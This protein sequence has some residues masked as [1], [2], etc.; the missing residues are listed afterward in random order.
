MD[1]PE[2]PSIEGGPHD[3]TPG[4]GDPEDA[5]GRYWTAAMFALIAVIVV[6]VLVVS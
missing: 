5:R 3:N 2:E 4:Q 6:V 1:T